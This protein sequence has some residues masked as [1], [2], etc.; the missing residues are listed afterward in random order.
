MKLLLD[1]HTLLWL[2][3]GDPKLSTQAKASIAD[4]TNVLLLRVESIWELE[5]KITKPKQKLELS[6]PLKTY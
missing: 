5:I 4:P 3:A 2:V 1:A 6:E